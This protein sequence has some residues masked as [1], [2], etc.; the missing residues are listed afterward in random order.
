MISQPHT[1]RHDK[2]DLGSLDLAVEVWISA[3]I[4]NRLPV[5]ALNPSTEQHVQTL[6]VETTRD[7]E[8]GG[9]RGE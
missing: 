7:R 1:G 8:G 5:N 4:K 2:L 6:Q 9:G 3:S